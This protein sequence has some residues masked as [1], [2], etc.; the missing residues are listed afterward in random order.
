MLFDVI[1]KLVQ[2]ES[3]FLDAE[4]NR[5]IVSLKGSIDCQRRLLRWIQFFLRYSFI[6]GSPRFINGLSGT[7][8]SIA[9]WISSS[10]P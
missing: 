4:G 6:E 3:D 2:N 8:L 7:C 9:R 1:A 10:M 5:R